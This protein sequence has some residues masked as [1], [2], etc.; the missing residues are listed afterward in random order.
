MTQNW[1]K[2]NEQKS[3]KEVGQSQVGGKKHRGL[4][5]ETQTQQTGMRRSTEA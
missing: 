3:G 4:S 5:W 1:G 2:D